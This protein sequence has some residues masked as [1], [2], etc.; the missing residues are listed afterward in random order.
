MINS[1]M[2][3]ELIETISDDKNVYLLA[4]LS[5]T[6]CFFT[7]KKR[8]LYAVKDEFDYQQE[9]IETDYLLLQTHVY[10]CPVKSNQTFDNG[11]YNL[12]VYKGNLADTNTESFVQLCCVYAN[13]ADGFSFKEFFYSLIAL[14]QLPTEQSFKN[15]VGLYGELKFMQYAS[16]YCNVDISTSWHRG[17][18]YSQYDFSNGVECIEV[19]S[20]LSKQTDVSIKHKQIFGRHSCFL[21]VMDC[22]RYDNGETIEEV[23]SSMY[24]N[25]MAFNG[26]NF[27]INLAKELKR[28][29]IQDIKKMHFGVCQIHFYNADDIN[30]LPAIPDSISQL[31]YRLDLS[32]FNELDSRTRDSIVKTFG[33]TL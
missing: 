2:L 4:S 24:Q 22:E 26:V 16:K 21:A 14:F 7:N 8:L 15:A 31:T 29:S 6:S 30:P 13:N 33:T 17:G 19:K 20:T 12:I 18:T 27:C 1:K 23:I 3:I 10:I 32:G 9:G 5:Q 25:P 11:Y 28:I